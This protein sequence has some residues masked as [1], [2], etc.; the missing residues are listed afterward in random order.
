[1]TPVAK[2]PFTISKILIDS[3]RERGDSMVR[4][5]DRFELGDTSKSEQKLLDTEYI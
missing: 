2:M 5:V 3:N 4:F 1:M